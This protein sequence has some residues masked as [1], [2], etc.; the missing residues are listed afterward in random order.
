MSEERKSVDDAHAADAGDAVPAKTDAEVLLGAVIELG[1]RDTP[2]GRLQAERERLGLDLRRVAEDLHLSV[3]SVRDIE[4]DRF[5]ELGAPVFAKG[6][7][8]RYATLLAI[9]PEDVLARYERLSGNVRAQES[10]PRAVDSSRRIDVMREASTFRI[11]PRVGNLFSTRAVLW[12]V[13]AVLVLAVSGWFAWTWRVAAPSNG[14]IEPVPTTQLLTVPPVNIDAS[15]IT[16]AIPPSAEPV[17]NP[18]VTLSNVALSP[19]AP[20]VALAA[21]SIASQPAILRSVNPPAGKV[22]LRLNFNQ[23]SWAEVHDGRGNRMMYD[24]GRPDLPRTIDAEPPVQV[25]LGYAPAASVE[26]N[27]RAVAIPVRRI[28]NS[29]ARFTVAADGSI[30]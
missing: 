4:A 19:P 7:L 29:V 16:A 14:A 9:S 20:V 5:A 17:K 18:S 11:A 30:N 15:V 21:P 28:A 13:L 23:E 12:G 2:G 24:V 10:V 3:Q 1:I 27:G 26:I 8:R 25:I 22:R 6:H